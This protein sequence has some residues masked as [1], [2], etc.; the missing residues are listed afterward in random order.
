ME[1]GSVGRRGAGSV[2]PTSVINTSVAV[3]T[4]LW[5]GKYILIPLKDAHADFLKRTSAAVEAQGHTLSELKDA[6][7]IGEQER[8]I[9]TQKL[10]KITDQLAQVVAGLADAKTLVV[11]TREVVINRLPPLPNVPLI[12]PPLLPSGPVNP[13]TFVE[14]KAGS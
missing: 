1:A 2:D 8:T 10:D 13:L 14:P 11:Q 5:I 12:V 7:I 3:I 6:L 9:S 4:L